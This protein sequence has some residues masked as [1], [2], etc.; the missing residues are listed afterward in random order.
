MF[1]RTVKARGGEG[2]QHEYVRLVEAYREHGK[3]KQRL[4]CSLGR[5]DLLAEHLDDLIALLRGERRPAAKN[6]AAGPLHAVGAW[7][8]GPMLVARTLWRE[9]GLQDVLDRRGGRGVG[10]GVAVADRAL[11]L[12]ANRLCVPTSEHGLARWLETDFVCDRRGRR[13][14]PQ[15]RDDA[16]RRASGWP[17]VR[18]SFRQLK[19][20]YRTLDQ[21]AARRLA[22]EEE[23]YLRLRDL[24][25]LKV[26]WV[27]YDLTSTYF[28][29]HGPAILGAHGHSRDGKPRNR[30]VLVGLVLVD[31]WPLTHHVFAG[32]WRDAKTVPDVLADLETRFGLRRVV[33]VGDRGMVTAANLTRLRER[34]HGYVVGLQRRRRE[35][36]YRYIERA[37][38]PW[39]DCPVGRAA[40]ERA[41]VPKTQV[42]EVASDEPGVRVFVVQSEERL[43]YERTQRLTAMARVRKQLA[44]LEKRVATGKL[45][46][47][48]KI[49]A[50]AARIL[51]RTH[52][53]RYYAWDYRDGR[54][55]FF[56]HPVNLKREEAYE[57]KYVI[58]TE[59]PQLTAVEAVTIYK[60][61]SEVE[62]AFANLKDV[63]E[64]RPIYHRTDARV[65]A[66]IFVAALAFLLH[67]AI[68]K[69]LKAA[70]L[71]LSSTEALHALR[72]VRVVDFMAAGQR[73]RS[74]T[75]GTDRAARVLTALGITELD[76]PTPPAMAATIT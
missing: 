35:A 36:I 48:A 68:E 58:Q 18:V 55:H 73:K 40:R 25:S 72:S 38:G 8:W 32:N 53:D 4:V 11:V 20:W 66:H 34:Q 7:D 67:R 28:E 70:S 6:D 31:G 75:R 61:L 54:F 63:I 57:G 17:R 21:L 50:A 43:A 22:I 27:F 37:T 46:A 19:Q 33:F 41:E 2:V 64:M 3:N 1:L 45:T 52:G 47:P 30:Q 49:G 13:W 15:W 39:T 44:A 24:F 69:K 60:E 5:K 62:R 16:E 29:G 74:V 9:L 12:V 42:Q 10:D 14:L 59:E 51:A 76:P 56:E 71:D 65:Q 26:D 23:L